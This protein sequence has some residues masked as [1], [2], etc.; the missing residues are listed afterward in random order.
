MS[1]IDDESIE[2]WNL[3]PPRRGFVA[4]W[5]AAPVPGAVDSEMTLA[6]LTDQEFQEAWGRNQGGFRRSDT[7]LARDSVERLGARGW[8]KED[9]EMVSRGRWLS[10]E[11]LERRGVGMREVVAEER[12]GLGEKEREKEKTY[13]KSKFR[14][15]LELDSWEPFVSERQEEVVKE[16]GATIKRESLT[17]RMGR[18]LTKLMS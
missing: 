8:M 1:D 16:E 13:R 11:N 9:W 15:M 18:K 3:Q 12:I 17:K 2:S 10:R 5:P 6:E 7:D 14:E 4:E